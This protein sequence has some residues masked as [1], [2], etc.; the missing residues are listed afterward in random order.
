MCTIRHSALCATMKRGMCLTL[1]SIALCMARPSRNSCP[2]IGSEP[3]IAPSP[4]ARAWSLFHCCTEHVTAKGGGGGGGGSCAEEPLLSGQPQLL[5]GSFSAV[6]VQLGRCCASRCL[7]D[8]VTSQS[9]WERRNACKTSG[10]KIFG[11][12]V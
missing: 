7:C 12:R 9:C 3:L 5:E 4:G 8:V 11:H 1:L 10:L 2:R 6:G